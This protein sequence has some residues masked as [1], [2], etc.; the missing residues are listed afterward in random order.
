MFVWFSKSH[1]VYS[2]M[3]ASLLHSI[4]I[5]LLL[6]GGSV[7]LQF[8]NISLVQLTFKSYL[9]HIKRKNF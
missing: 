6:P 3:F 8:D 7:M 4:K 5:L 1:S 2:V 9:W